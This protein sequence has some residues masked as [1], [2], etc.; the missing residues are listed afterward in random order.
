MKVKKSAEVAWRFQVNGETGAWLFLGF[1]EEK[2]DVRPS[3]YEGQG[4]FKRHKHVLEQALY[5]LIGDRR[6]VKSH[7]KPEHVAK[8]LHVELS[9]SAELCSTEW[10]HD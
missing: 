7:C 5:T 4:T 8:Q 3:I 1:W 9:M 2:E 10:S 6:A